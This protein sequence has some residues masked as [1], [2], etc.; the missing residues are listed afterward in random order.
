MGFDTIEIK[1]V[2]Q[3]M[4]VFVSQGVAKSQFLKILKF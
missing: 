3:V 4:A 2:E 1:L